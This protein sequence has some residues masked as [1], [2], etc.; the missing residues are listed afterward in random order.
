MYIRFVSL[1]DRL[2]TYRKTKISNRNFLVIAAIL[3]GVFAG[4]A[5]SL[6]KTL[7]HHIE[8]FLQTDLNWQYKYYLYLLFPMIGIFL[9]VLY[10]RRFIKKGKFSNNFAYPPK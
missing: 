5:A 1:V 8:K 3:V 4:L 10:V 7:T 6:L 2:N 9:S